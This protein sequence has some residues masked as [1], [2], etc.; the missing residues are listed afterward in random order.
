[1]YLTT[2]EPVLL[3]ATQERQAQVGPMSVERV[4]LEDEDPVLLEDLKR[5]E[6]AGP[7]LFG[8]IF[9]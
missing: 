2:V 8:S 1:M 7:V 3:Q 6:E 5:I 9:G 4:L